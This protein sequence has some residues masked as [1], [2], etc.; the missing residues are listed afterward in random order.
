MKTT[1]DRARYNNGQ[2]KTGVSFGFTLVELMVVIAVI[3]IS[4][5]F[6]APVLRNMLLQHEFNGSVRDVLSAIRQARLVAIEQNESV[7]VTVDT[8]NGT[9]QAF[10]DDGGTNTVDSEPNGIPDLAQN[11]N[12]N[13][14]DN[15]RLVVNIS[16][17]NDVTITAANFAG[18]PVFRFDNRGFPMS[19]AIPMNLGVLTNGTINLSSALGRNRQIDLFRSGHSRIQ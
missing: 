17:P 14:G 9:I 11:W 1:G 10:V 5:V 7:V 16:V 13:S 18:N 2:G 4:A 8:V 12:W 6:S 15:E 19:K 3:A